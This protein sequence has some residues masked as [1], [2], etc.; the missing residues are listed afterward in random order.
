MLKKGHKKNRCRV[1]Y[2]GF[3]KKMKKEKITG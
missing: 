3:K 2:S 1:A